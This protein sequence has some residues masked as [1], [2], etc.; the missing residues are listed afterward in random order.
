MGDSQLTDIREASNQVGDTDVVMET[1]VAPE[2]PRS[3]KDCLIGTGLRASDTKGSSVNGIPVIDFFEQVNKLVIQ[4]MEHQIGGMIGR[5]A[6]L[7]FST[8]NGVRGKFTRIVVYI[9]L[10]KALI[11]EVLINGVLQE[12]EY[13]HLP[14][15]CFS[16]GHYRHIQDIC[17]RLAS[18]QPEARGGAL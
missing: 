14:T 17:P 13:E 3:W 7:D 8:D 5:V 6:K 18:E 10:G 12:I 11:S 2:R 1:I 4:D 16:C 15:M 9:N